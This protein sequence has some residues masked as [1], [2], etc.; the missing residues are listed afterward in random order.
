MGG[1]KTFFFVLFTVLLVST[2]HTWALV[3]EQVL[4]LANRN[5]ARSVGLARYYM[6]KRGIPPDHLVT[7]W[8]TDTESCSREAYEKKV[9]APVVRYLEEN[10]A[11]PIRCLV[12]VYGVPLRVHPPE[13]TSEEKS[14]YRG[15]KREIAH[16]SERLKQAKKGSE[17]QKTMRRKFRAISV[18]MGRLSKK[19]QRAALD[20]EIALA[21]AAPYELSKWIPNPYFLGF[22]GKPMPA[23][24]PQRK[25]VLM[26][27]RLDGPSPEIVRR[28][29]DEAMEA[30]RTGLQGKAYFDARWPRPDA[31][32]EP[33]KLTYRFYDLSIHKAAELVEKN[34]HIPV[35]LDAKET[36]FQPGECEEAALYC[37]WYS[38]HQYIDAFE[39]R[40][41]SVG[42]HIASSECGT[43]KGNKSQV[44]CKRMLEEGAA[45][46]IGPVDEPYLHS[47]PVPQMFFGLLLEGRWT[48]AECYTLS[49]PILSWQ[50]VLVGDPLYKPFNR[51]EV[52]AEDQ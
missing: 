11:K 21:L 25:D 12:T 52:S 43:L 44:W 24:A 15:L 1:C 6:E 27:A 22:R 46:T 14:R 33:T 19:S 34:S 20:S 17:E 42:Y 5:A 39:W 38:H 8:L 23:G 48:L 41:G 18:E 29:V 16:V 40:P 50:M 49:L 3:P 10:S 51:K 36:L 45:V 2:G 35:I 7:L 47:F 28:I 13:M 4:V 31:E 26:V 32:K 37:G 9:L 30:E